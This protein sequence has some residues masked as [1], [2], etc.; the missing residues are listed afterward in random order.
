MEENKRI[1][2]ATWEV[3][4]S[5]YKLKL[6]VW[7]NTYHLVNVKIDCRCYYQAGGAV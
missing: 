3:D 2:W 7:Q 4:G 5:E 1:P 6:T